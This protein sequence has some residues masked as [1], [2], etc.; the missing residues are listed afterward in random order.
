LFS[1]AIVLLPG[2]D[3]LASVSTIDDPA[4][5]GEEVERVGYTRRR[6]A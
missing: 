6:A 5:L 1:L 3:I 2:Q 4:V